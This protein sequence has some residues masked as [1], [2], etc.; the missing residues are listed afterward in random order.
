MSVL[1]HLTLLALVAA[2]ASAAVAA[3][4]PGGPGTNVA[5]NLGQ[6]IDGDLGSRSDA[7]WFRAPLAA[8][9]LYA[10]SLG[11]FEAADVR[12]AVRG[13]AGRILKSVNLNLA[14]DPYFGSQQLNFRPETGGTY[15][16]SVEVGTP[17]PGGTL[18]PFPASYDITLFQDNS[19]GFGDAVRLSVGQEFS[20]RLESDLDQ[21]FFVVRLTQGQ[22]IDLISRID[23]RGSAVL[24]DRNRKAVGAVDYEIGKLSY[25]QPT[26]T[27][28][29][30]VRIN[31]IGG[32]YTL[33]VARASRGTPTAGSDILIGTNGAD[34]INGLG[35][36]DRIRGLA[37]NDT[38]LGGPG[39][40]IILGGPG[41]DRVN[42]GPGG[43]QIQAEAGDDL[44]TGGPGLEFM[45]GGPGI[46]RYVFSGDAE[47][48]YD[49][50]TDMFGPKGRDYISDFVRGEKL[51]LR[52]VD[53]DAT[54]TGRQ[55]FSFVGTR[56]FTGP[57]QVRYFIVNQPSVGAQT[58][59][60]LNTDADAQ[61]ESIIQLQLRYPL[62][63]DDFILRDPARTP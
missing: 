59:V 16:V 56:A 25:Y 33:Q 57:A 7:D 42:G 5:L 17:A 55:R 19:S 1:R 45:S 61:P 10:V 47:R 2:P 8:G 34:T 44:V 38:L 22:P 14:T 58:I 46:D 32:G 24:F 43:D 63:A 50:G 3:D 35:G 37:G 23:F 40:D 60:Q 21:D 11:T 13:P 26:Y 4:V 12:V 27:G 31:D 28:D 20:G 41:N 48:G 29:H 9:K 54:R 30:F 6:R 39:D 49:A 18:P 36:G 52:G 51:D 15:F 53:A 62:R